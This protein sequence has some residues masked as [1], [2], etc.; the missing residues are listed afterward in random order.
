MWERNTILGMKIPVA[1][2]VAMMAYATEGSVVVNTVAIQ[3]LEAGKRRI[4]VLE[5][6]EVMR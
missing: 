6:I 3:D 2:V 4:I 5:A 1:A